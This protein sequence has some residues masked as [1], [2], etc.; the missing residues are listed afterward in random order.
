MHLP[1]FSVKVASF[2]RKN[3]KRLLMR[4]ATTPRCPARSNAAFALPQSPSRHPLAVPATSLIP[5]SRTACD[6]LPGGCRTA[7]A[8][9]APTL[10]GATTGV[11]SAAMASRIVVIVQQ[12]STSCHS[13]AVEGRRVPMARAAEIRSATGTSSRLAPSNSSQIRPPQLLRLLSLS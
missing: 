13:R 7:V 2:R 10:P 5:P 11:T 9:S 3:G 6:E 1:L 8:L 4:S 12:S